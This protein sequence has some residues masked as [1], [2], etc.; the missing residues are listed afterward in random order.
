MCAP[1]PASAQ[2]ETIEFY[3]LDTIGSVRVVFDAA[4]N[5]VRRSDFEPFGAP[6]NQAAIANEHIYAG[7]WREEAG[8][9]YAQARM[10]QRSTGR[11]NAPDPIK[12]GH[13]E[14]Q[15]WNRY[16]Y[17]LNS[18][19]SY[20]DTSGLLSD[21]GISRGFCGAEHS[22]G[23]CG[24]QSLFWDLDGGGG[25]GFV[26]GGEFAAA[27]NR[28]YVPGM[29]AEVWEA[30]DQFNLRSE[31]A[32]AQARQESAA[33]R[34]PRPGVSTSIEVTL[35]NEKKIKLDEGPATHPFDQMAE[36]IWNRTNALTRPGVYA[37]FL[38]V[39]AAGAGAARG[40]LS[41]GAQEFLFGRGGSGLLN[42]RFTKDI[43]RVGH[44]WQGDA[45]TGVSVFRIAVGSKRLPFH[46][47]KTLWIR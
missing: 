29:P 47:H 10:Y 45:H 6:V 5:V 22:F 18:P 40:F 31:L 25:G 41:R 24:G 42:G 23:A 44:G 39:S 11:I 3:G 1:S 30:L 4:G 27:Q 20:T 16:A 33:R 14:P 36:D 9:D 2:T 34:E 15:R 17:S 21:A 13:M 37:E 32:F 35:P 43:V 12:A 46:W 28:G 7:L 19:V 8:L 26:F 38:T